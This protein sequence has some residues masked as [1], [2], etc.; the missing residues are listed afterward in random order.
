M[1]PGYIESVGDAAE[2][3]GVLM[4]SKLSFLVGTSVIRS[5]HGSMC[6][7]LYL[8]VSY[9]ISQAKG[10]GKGKRANPSGEQRSS[11][12]GRS[13]PENVIHTDTP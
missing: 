10:D 4:F 5:M 8:S 2:G 9:R 3:G 6:I 13:A 7:L 11:P 1:C 12:G